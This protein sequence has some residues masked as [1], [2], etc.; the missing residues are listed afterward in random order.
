MAPSGWPGLCDAGSAGS[1][2]GA[3][4]LWNPD[5]IGA[6]GQA[7]MKLIF[8]RHAQAEGNH[9]RRF[10]GSSDVPLS[11]T[12]LLQA[13]EAAKCVPGVE[14][15]YLSPMMRCVQTA[16]LVFNGVP[17]TVIEELRESD[18]GIFEGKCHHELV[19]NPYYLHWLKHP[20]AP[21]PASGI[22]PMGAV[23]G[24]SQNA[25]GEIVENML[26]RHIQMGAIVGHGGVLM[27]MLHAYALPR[28]PVYDWKLDNCAWIV[29]QL[30]TNPMELLIEER[31]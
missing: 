10:I 31:E 8:L 28:R 2:G 16:K 17:S 7:S 5:G 27:H 21:C 26:R 29:A 6:A 13:R 18:F 14:H 4:F 11:Q 30:N 3:Y 15:V 22:E 24:R 25:L 12:G 23:K 9:E 20:E 19:G 1:T